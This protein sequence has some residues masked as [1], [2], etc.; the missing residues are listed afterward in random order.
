MVSQSRSKA[1][2][3]TGIIIDQVAAGA[4]AIQSLVVA[5]AKAA[6]AFPLTAGQPFVG[7]NTASTIAGIAAGALA[8]KKA[9]SEIGGGGSTASFSAPQAVGGVTAPAFNIIGA[10]P[11]SQLAQTLQSQD[12]PIK[13]FV[14][15]SDV[16]SQQQ[17][18]RNIITTATIG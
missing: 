4:Q 12:N 11:T 17:L 14:V 3:V 10:N 1:A 16:T 8:A 18:D 15:G 2:A 5:N 7:I 9:I 6:A 13:A